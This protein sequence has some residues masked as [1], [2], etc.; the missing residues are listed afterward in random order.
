MKPSS[1]FAPA[2]AF[3]ITANAANASPQDIHFLTE[4][5]NDFQS[6]KLEYLSFLGTA[7]SVPMDLAP[8]ATH[9]LTY[10]D[11]SYTT[12]LADTSINFAALTSFVTRLPWHTRIQFDAA[13]TDD[14]TGT[15]T[16]TATGT[17]GHTSPS[18]TGTVTKTTTPTTSPSPGGTGHTSPSPTTGTDG[19]HTAT[20]QTETV[21]GSETKTTSTHG[22]AALV[23]APLGALIGGVA[24]AL[25]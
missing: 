9:V 8:L 21:T 11:D 19:T 5:V 24:F 18:P 14:G 25:L 2:V 13:A 22:A 4:L 20:A 7:S 3:A 1:I 15:T 17:N 16:V 12:M 23:S 6:H 10:T